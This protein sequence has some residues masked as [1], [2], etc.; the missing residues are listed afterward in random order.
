MHLF[1]SHPSPSQHID[2]NILTVVHTLQT[3]AVLSLGK[4]VF[5]YRALTWRH[6]PQDHNVHLHGPEN[7]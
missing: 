4:L 2:F 1:T 6:D 7:F 3:G 5:T